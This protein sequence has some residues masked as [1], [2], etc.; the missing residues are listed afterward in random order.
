M[1]LNVN[2]DKIEYVCFNQEADIPLISG[3]RKVIEMFMYLGSIVSST[4]G[5]IIIRITEARTA[6]NKI[7]VIWKSDSLDKIKPDFFQATVV[8]VQHY[9]F[10]SWRLIK[11]IKKKKSKGTT[12]KYHELY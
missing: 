11:H 2:A 5:N 8:S 1:D 9:R 3:S 12:Q 7:S 4:E 6:I 10:N